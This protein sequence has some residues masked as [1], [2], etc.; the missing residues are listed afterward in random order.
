MYNT[1]K[2]QLW[3]GELRTARGN[4]IVFQ[5]SQL[6]EAS[7]GRVYLYNTVRKTIVEYV[8][9]IVKVNLHDLDDAQVKAALDQFGD[10]WK[11]VRAEFML[12]HQA[13]IDL[14]KVPDTAPPKKVKPAPEP[15]DVSDD[16][17]VDFDDADDGDTDDD[18]DEMGDNLDD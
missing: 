15:D 11:A 2:K 8:E 14:S 1:A 13:R 17:I 5:D 9:D 18:Y 6:P 4:T 10:A 12:K 3:V 16:D 7:T